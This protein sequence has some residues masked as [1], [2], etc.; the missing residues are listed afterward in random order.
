MIDGNGGGPHDDASGLAPVIPLFG[1][2]VPAAPPSAPR[3]AAAPPVDDAA[4]VAGPWHASWI[5]DVSDIAAPSRPGDASDDGGA[6][7][8][9]LAEKTLL[10]RL[11]G[12][13]L[14]ER[15]ARDVLAPFD[16]DDSGTERIVAMCLRSGYLDD[17]ALAEQLVHVGMD[18]K[19]QGRT[20]IARTLASR[21]IPRDVADE[22]LLALPD[23]DLERALDFARTKARS[24]R[25]LDHDTAVRRLMGQLARRGYGGSLATTAA[26]QALLEGGVG[27]SS[28]RF[29]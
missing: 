14:S 26:K 10:R 5:D 18:R 23:D 3:R 2:A 1:G 4:E 8:A 28:V 6:A 25:S 11:R 19:G 17:A 29:R 12:K 15:E 21:G 24:M 16:L 13:R 27:T 9:D 20:V 22:A 7:E